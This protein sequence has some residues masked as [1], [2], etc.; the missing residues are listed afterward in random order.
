MFGYIIPNLSSL[1]DAQRTRYRSVYCGLCHALRERHGLTGSATL[2]NDLTFLAMLLNSLYCETEEKSREARCLTHPLKRHAYVSSPVFEYAADM[3]VALAYHKCLDNWLD[4]HNI[5]SRS[6]AL[7]LKRAYARIAGQ[8]PEKC[9]AIERWLDEIH[10]IEAEKQSGLDAPVNSTGR[11]LGELFRWQRADFWAESL[12][13]V[14]DGL[15]RFI[16]MMDAY[17][18]LPGD[19]RRNRYNPRAEYRA[20]EDFEPMCR[21]ALLMMV[22]DCTQEF[23]QLPIV[24]DADILRNILYSGI[25]SRYVQIQKKKEKQMAKSDDQGA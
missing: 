7:L 20:R 24:Q 5:L 13:R 9:L 8:Y 14:G 18:D 11:M 22:A 10:Q 19:A 16:Y 23:E 6:E 2:S 25:W 3:N 1:D 4:D 15:G 17:D 12:Y 21:D